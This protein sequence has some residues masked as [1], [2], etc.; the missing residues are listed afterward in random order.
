[1]KIIVGERGT[2]KTTALLDRIQEDQRID[3]LKRK[4]DEKVLL[5]VP[6]MINV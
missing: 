3:F 1:M 5:I 6:E 4:Y 2:G